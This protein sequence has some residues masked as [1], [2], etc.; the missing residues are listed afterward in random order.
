MAGR[1]RVDEGGVLAHYA[2]WRSRTVGRSVAALG[3]ADLTA[4]PYV[5]N[6][7]IVDEEDR[8][9][10]DEL[11]GRYGAEPIDDRELPE[12]PEGI[13]VREEGLRGPVAVRLKFREVPAVDDQDG[14]LEQAV[15][16][17]PGEVFVSSE[18]GAAVAAMTARFAFDGRPI[19]LNLYGEPFAMPLSTATESAI[20]GAG[21]NP[22]AYAAFA[23]R[24]RMV[25]AWQLMDSV[26][27][28]RSNPFVVLAVLD[29]GFWLDGNGAPIVAGGQTAS[30][31]GAGV[32]QLNLMAEGTPAGGMSPSNGWHGN[33]VASA[34]AGILNNAAGAAGSGGTVATPMLFRTDISVDQL[35]RAARICAAWGLDVLNMSIGTWGDAEIWFPTTAWDKAFRF[36]A[37]NGVVMIAAAGNSSLDLPNADDHV[38]PATRTPGVLTVGALDASDN[39][40]GFSNYG[41]S[42]NL[43][44]PGTAIPVAPDGAA[45]LG[46]TKNGTSFA[47][48]IVAGVA[49]MMRSANPSLSA[50]D[51][52]RI[53]VETG[54]QGTGRVTK[55]LDAFAAVFAAIGAA[56][57]DN[58]EPN[59][60]PATAGRLIATGPGGALQP[61]LGPFT[62]RSKSGDT[63]YWKFRV[64]RFSTVTVAVDWYER[65][66]TLGV[67]VEGEDPDVR[68][69]DDLTRTNT[70]GGLTLTGL[71]PP[72]GY[73][74]RV[75]GGGITAYSLRVTQRPASLPRDIFEK[76]DSFESAAVMLFETNKWTPFFTR[77]WGPGT[78]DATLHR[79]V[80]Y[81]PYIG[82]GTKGSVNVD[83]FRLDVPDRKIFSRPA[84]AVFDSDQVVDVTLYDEH[85]NVIDART[86]LRHVKL[87]PPPKST[88]YLRVTGSQVT[89]YR[90]STRMETDSHI[91]PGPWQEELHVFPKW[92]GDPPPLHLE[93]P[94]THY[95]HELGEDRG[96]GSAL[97]FADPGVDLR[98]GL[99]DRT[100]EV[101][102]EARTLGD[103]LL[104]DIEGL[105]PGPYIVQITRPDEATGTELRVVP[106]LPNRDLH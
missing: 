52:R 13:Q 36:A 93:D 5:A 2:D 10:I 35:M 22:F 83:Y 47:A 25:E 75:T 55:G 33:S 61:G 31:L 28:M 86:N 77:T 95:L 91:I 104:L 17:R 46:S 100:G 102:R 56:L 76:N 54:W 7:V 8:E 98:I 74:I 44:A 97:A 15:G 73:R 51:I 1:V 84:V 106:P 20:P 64:E 49:A 90:I 66:S 72:G 103:R 70:A 87:Y 3:P 57:P 50:H 78:Y 27:R 39:A 14:L 37:D 62:T 38:R 79:D 18:M 88:C 94:V 92:W 101:I 71:L 21:A 30:D 11:V 85:R 48:P 23:G 67:L 9:L 80:L 16:D 81:S 40:A 19:G 53:L 58:N 59:N 43:W 4:M 89:R 68:G 65:L 26:Q 42:V 82:G 96:E 12:P 29:N 69:P 34:G 105:E 41:S 60:T 45:P 6:E 24:T 99:I 63:D 32:M